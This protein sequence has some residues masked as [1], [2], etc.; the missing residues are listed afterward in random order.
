MENIGDLIENPK[1]RVGHP[2]FDLRHIGS[3]HIGFKGES[4]LGQA[5][6][7]PDL[8]CVHCDRLQQAFKS[9]CHDTKRAG[10]EIVNPRNIIDNQLLPL[11]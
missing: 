4:F 2:A 7:L 8:P 10:E 3:I 6:A 5:S 1:R 11:E 9:L